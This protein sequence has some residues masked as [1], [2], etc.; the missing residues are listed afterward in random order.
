M[1]YYFDLSRLS[2][3]VGILPDP[4]DT[5]VCTGTAIHREDP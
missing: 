1:T 2:G 3:C 4:G 5:V